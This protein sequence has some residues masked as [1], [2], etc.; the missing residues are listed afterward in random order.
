MWTIKEFK[1]EEAKNKWI[2]K[3]KGRYQY[4][5]IFVNNGHALEV[6][7]LRKVY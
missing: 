4:V 5:E 3:N 2:E 7:K 1:S 6:R